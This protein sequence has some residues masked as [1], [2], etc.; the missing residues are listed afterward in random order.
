MR[1][2]LAVL[3]ALSLGACATPGFRHIEPDARAKLTSMESVLIVTQSEIGAEINTSKASVATGGG[4]VGALIESGIN[5]ARTK[6]AEE[7]VAPIRDI[8]IDFDFGAILEQELEAELAALNIANAQEVTLLRGLEAGTPN[9]MIEQSGASAVLF[10]NS[11]YNLSAEFD[12]MVATAVVALYPVSENL[13]P[14]KE[15]VD[16]DNKR[17]ELSDNIYRNTFRVTQP[18]SDLDKKEEN[19]AALAER[20]ASELTGP[21]SEAAKILARAIAADMQIDAAE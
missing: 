3:V 12:E 15:K 5:N 1:N 17:A 21:L 8:M 13:Y 16:A 9:T 4:I 10:I 20:P 14:Y 18:L 11:T 7:L 19:A 2:F 6:T